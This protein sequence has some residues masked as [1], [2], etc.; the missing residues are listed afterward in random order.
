MSTLEDVLTE[1]QA[2]LQFK[3]ALKKNP[4][5]ALTNAGLVLSSADLVKIKTILNIDDGELDGRI[6]K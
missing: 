2:N 4:E 1:W 5:Q 3:E 6:N